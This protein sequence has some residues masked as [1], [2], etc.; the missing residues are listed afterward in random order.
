MDDVL[1][2]NME[3]LVSENRAVVSCLVLPCCL[4]QGNRVIVRRGIMS[5]ECVCCIIC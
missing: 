1:I 2:P 4:K 3:D 5:G